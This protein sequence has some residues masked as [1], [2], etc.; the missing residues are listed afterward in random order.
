MLS[1]GAVAVA[2]LSDRPLVP[3][4]RPWQGSALLWL[5]GA[6]G[7][8]SQT[9]GRVPDSGG[10][11]LSSAQAG[12]RLGSI[13]DTLLTFW[14]SAAMLDRFAPTDAVF[15]ISG[16]TRFPKYFEARP[17]W[18]DVWNAEWLLNGEQPIV[19][20]IPHFHDATFARDGRLLAL[21]NAGV[22][23][24]ANDS[25]YARA[26]FALPGG[27]VATSRWLE[28]STYRGESPAAYRLPGE[29][30]SKIVATDI[31]MLFL[32]LR[33]GSIAVVRDPGAAPRCEVEPE[34]RIH[35]ADAPRPPSYLDGTGSRDP[36]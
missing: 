23:W 1:D 30:A 12:L 13:G 11:Y 29:W 3:S 6:D 33:D 32:W 9:L 18:E 5:I 26:M 16:S 17:A 31:G 25:P 35:E 4:P 28:I 7:T 27:W 8:A 34:I 22:R 14:L 21:R 10:T 19:Y 24:H 2:P 15:Q 36:L 20:H